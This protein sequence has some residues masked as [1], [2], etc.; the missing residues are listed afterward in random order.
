MKRQL[1]S[2]TLWAVGEIGGTDERVVPILGALLEKDELRA[3]DRQGIVRTLGACGEAAVAPLLQVLDSSEDVTERAVAIESLG[4]IG[5]PSAKA[6]PLLEKSLHDD[7]LRFP[8]GAALARVGKAAAP[9]LVQALKDENPQ[10]RIAVSMGLFVIA[11]G[12]FEHI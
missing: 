6:I 5:A 4:K 3:Y 1:L 7:D 2:S 11:E 12:P 8:A 10:V 9:V